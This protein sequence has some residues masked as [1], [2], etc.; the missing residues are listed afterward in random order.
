MMTS[1]LSSGTFPV[2]L[3][4]EPAQPEVDSQVLLS[5]RQ[6]SKLGCGWPRCRACCAQCAAA[7]GARHCTGGARCCVL[8]AAARSRLYVMIYVQGLLQL[9]ITGMSELFPLLCARAA[10][11]G[12]L[13]LSPAS[14]GEALIPLSVTLVC[15]PLLYPAVER[16]IG[17][18]GCF[19]L[20]A[21]TVTIVCLLMSAL[22][23]LRA[24]SQ[25]LMWLGLC[26]VGVLRGITGP[27]VFSSTTV[28]FNDLLLT[29]IGYYNGV[30]S[31][32]SSLC[33]G[34]APLIFGTVFAAVSAARA[35][36]P[37][38]IH[39]PFLLVLLV[40]ALLVVLVGRDPARRRKP[41]RTGRGKVGRTSTQS[42]P[43]QEL[44]AVP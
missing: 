14:L 2:E 24:A 39:L 34:L 38:D 42:G 31:S 44:Q 20:G 6:R 41:R 37:L 4:V 30:A 26:A 8:L 12:G 32:V 1:T 5:S 16:R 43:A 10:S 29:D 13:G 3:P 35:P 11:D 19:R 17:H 22:P 25:E 21:A 23:A 15:T 28:I 7:T 27:L 33:R 36:F 40:V 18:Y 9:G